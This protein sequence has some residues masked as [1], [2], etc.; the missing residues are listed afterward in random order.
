MPNKSL[1]PISGLD[2]ARI[3]QPHEHPLSEKHISP[4]ALSVI[5][6][7]NKQGFNAF[8]VGGAV[9]DLYLGKKPKDFDVATDAKPEEIIKIFKHSRII[10]RRFRI[11]HVVKGREII[12]VTTFRGDASGL[13]PAANKSGILIRDNAFGTVAEDAKRRDISINSLYFNLLDHCI[14]DFNQGIEDLQDRKIRII[15]DAKQRYTED[16][17]RILRVLRFQAKLGFELDAESYSAIAECA[18]LLQLI[19]KARLFDESIKLFCN[20]Y[21]APVFK[22]LQQHELLDVVI[23][24]PHLITDNEQAHKLVLSAFRNSDLR[25][26]QDKTVSPVFVFAVIF[27]PHL[28]QQLKHLANQHEKLHALQQTAESLFKRQKKTSEITRR[29]QE[30]IIDIWQLQIHLE[31]HYHKKTA[32]ELLKFPRFRAAYDF[33]VLRAQVG[34]VEQA[35]ADWWTPIAETASAEPA[36]PTMRPVRKRKPNKNRI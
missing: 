4:F 12:E 16:P 6:T 32:Y 26:A 17:V 13:K 8:L 10:G 7:L 11:T 20:G 23:H 28:T 5:S 22:L 18:P 24:D 29:I 34:E 14:Y 33:L 21:S 36:Q 35:I 1:K 31:H 9:R 15:G 25:V 30:N 2:Q 27:W 19:S 3:Y